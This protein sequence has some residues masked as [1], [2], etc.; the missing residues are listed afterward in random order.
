MEQTRGGSLRGS[1]I[2]SSSVCEEIAGAKLSRELQAP[3]G[4]VQKNE[5]GSVHDARK[6]ERVNHMLLAMGMSPS[7][8]CMSAALKKAWLMSETISAIPA[9]DPIFRSRSHS[10]TSA[11]AVSDLFPHATY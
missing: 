4:E 2:C 7:D 11:C 1:Q 10:I 8:A 3:G 5:I 6:G 9:L